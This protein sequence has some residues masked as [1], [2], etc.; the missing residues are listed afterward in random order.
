MN[1]LEKISQYQHYSVGFHEQFVEAFAKTPEEMRSA[2]LNLSFEKGKI[3]ADYLGKMIL[4]GNAESWLGLANMQPRLEKSASHLA[5]LFEDICAYVSNPDFLA[6]D[7]ENE[8]SEISAFF[9]EKFPKSY[10]VGEKY[11]SRLVDTI[12]FNK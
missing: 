6:S 10:F 11:H 2:S 3:D 5:E 12:S 1:S 9:V 4:S 7:F 8:Y